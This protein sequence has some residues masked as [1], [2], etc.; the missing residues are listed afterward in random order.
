MVT[1]T[2]EQGASMINAAYRLRTSIDPSHPYPRPKGIC[3]WYGYVAGKGFHELATACI[4][5]SSWSEC[6]VVRLLS[7]LRGVKIVYLYSLVDC[8]TE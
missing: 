6:G 8:H 5:S 4:S 3:G 7:F 1:V 2:I